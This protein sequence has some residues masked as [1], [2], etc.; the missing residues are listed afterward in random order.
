MDNAVSID[1]IAV[2]DATLK[3]GTYGA[4]LVVMLV[5]SPSAP[6]SAKQFVSYCLSEKARTDMQAIGFTPLK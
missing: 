3:D 6:D 2:S 1:G 5:T 4:S